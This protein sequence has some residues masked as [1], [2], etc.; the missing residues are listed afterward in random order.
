MRLA[1]TDEWEIPKSQNQRKFRQ[2]HYA[3]NPE[4]T[5]SET[6]TSDSDSEGPEARLAKKY[7]KV[8]SDSE[9]EDNIPLAELARRLEVRKARLKQESADLGSGDVTQNKNVKECKS[10]NNTNK[11]ET[12]SENTS[13]SDNEDSDVSGP[14]EGS[15]EIVLLR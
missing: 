14:T 10:E 9:V 11:M 5:E 15:D 1:N 4:A 12:A 3:I 13:A 8:R 6:V 2:A 7:R